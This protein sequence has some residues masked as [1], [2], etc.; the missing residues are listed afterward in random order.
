MPCA[1]ERWGGI[2]WTMRNSPLSHLQRSLKELNE[3]L[4]VPVLRNGADRAMVIAFV[5]S[6]L[7]PSPVPQKTLFQT[8]GHRHFRS[9][10]TDVC[11]SPAP[12]A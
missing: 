10:A 6:D 5:V 4:V 12:R 11:S 7:G 2:A 3:T 8:P 1:L 9:G